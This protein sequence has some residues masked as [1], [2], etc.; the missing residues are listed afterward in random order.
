MAL[1]WIEIAD[2]SIKIGLG[3]LLS[4]ISAYVINRQNHTKIIEKEYLSKH[5]QTLENVT[6]EI[7]E[8]THAVLKYW[9]YM[10]DWSRNKEKGINNSPEKSEAIKEL[11]SNLFGQFKG[12]TNS[13]GSL[14]LIGCKEQ[15]ESLR[16][17]GNLISEFIRYASRNNDDMESVKL[18]EWREKILA[19][20]IELY[21]L[22]NSAYKNVKT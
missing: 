4:G 13:E 5:R 10:V 17:Y 22:L 1:T 9:S 21:T 14:L 7:E 2:T 12:L 18:E 8:I 16:N 15:Q 19:E 20:R 11:R 6:L 3:A